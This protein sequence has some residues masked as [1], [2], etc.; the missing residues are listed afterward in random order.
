MEP[1]AGQPHASWQRWSEQAESAA[2][3]IGRR[4]RGG[5]WWGPA[6]AT[7]AAAQRWRHERVAG[8]SGAALD[9]PGRAAHAPRSHGPHAPRRTGGSEG[10]VT[11]LLPVISTLLVMQG[12]EV[13]ANVDRTHLRV[14]EELMLTIRAHTRAA[15]PVDIILP[16]LDGVAVVGSRDLTEGALRG[17]P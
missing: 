8:R 15:G 12:A 6:A 17:R 11:G 14:G 5:R 3:A 9:R 7:P 1:G 16:P 2:S 13:T 10:L 4:R